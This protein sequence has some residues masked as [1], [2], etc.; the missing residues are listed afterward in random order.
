MFGK[1]S[2]KMKPMTKEEAARILKMD[3]AAFEAFE[4]AYAAADLP[5]TDEG[6][7]RNA[8]EAA[9]ASEGIVASSEEAGRI[10]GRIVQELLAQ[11]PA[12][13]YDGKTAHVMERLADEP[14][15]MVTADEIAA[16]PEGQRPQLAGSLVRRDMG[17][18]AGLMLLSVY[19]MY[20][21]AKTK[22]KK[23]DAYNLF[24]QGLDIQDLDPILYEILG[25][26]QNSMGHWLPHIVDA[27]TQGASA[28]KVPRTTVIK[29]PLPL[30]QLTRLDYGL[31]TRTTLDIV[32][33]Y[34][35]KAFGLSLDKEYFIKNGV[36]SSKYD[37][38]NAHVKGAREV[39][40]LGEYL[41]YIHNEATMM[42][43]PLAVPSTYGA[44][45]TN[46]WVVREFVQDV[47]GNP[48]I[49]HGL[50]LHTEYRLFVDFD[51]K[52][53][54]GMNPYWDPEV[55]K[56]HFGAGADRK[57]PHMAHD[58]LAYSAHEETLMRRYSENKGYVWKEMEKLIQDVEG[59]SGQ[60][61]VDVM[62][63][64][65]DFWLIDM[66]WAQNSA[67][68]GCVPEHLRVPMEEEWLPKIEKIG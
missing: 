35:I 54:I 53:V 25:M 6:I 10:A 41:L 39:R 26:N 29:V 31:L 32:D 4:R 11:T 66:A 64:G 59:M 30:L 28:F 13:S 60:W 16:L 47:E 33:G 9:A 18:D 19:Q 15:K 8:K 48:C 42:A 67:F 14:E 55:M 38:R 43:G 52:K 40:E 12:W 62:Q 23:Q 56:R 46:E 17:G 22:R 51:T 24:R 5:G 34:C 44:A 7:Y 1:M 63:N 27:V 58:Y 21:N 65:S 2:P 3:P 20:K 57:D 61:S 49:Y 45:T 50:P 36:F 37:F 68:Y